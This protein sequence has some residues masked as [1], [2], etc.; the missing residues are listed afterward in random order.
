LDVARFGDD[1]TALAK[2]RQRALMEPIIFWQ[3]F[4][5]MQIAQR[6]K[7]IWDDCEVD[8][9]PCAICIDAIG[10]G[11]GVVDRLNEMAAEGLFEG[12]QIIGIN[13]SESASIHDKFSRLRDELWWRARLGLSYRPYL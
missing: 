12:T 13:V 10:V 4:N 2:R 3:G 5:L 11:A 6:I 8:D 9:R 7:V 1:R